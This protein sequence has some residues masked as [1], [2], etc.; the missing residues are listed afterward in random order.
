MNITDIYSAALLA[1]YDDAN[2]QRMERLLVSARHNTTAAHEAELA[3]C[4]ES[5]P[6]EIRRLCFGLRIGDDPLYPYVERMYS[7]DGWD[8]FAM[9]RIAWLYAVSKQRVHQLVKAASDAFRAHKLAPKLREMLYDR[10]EYGAD[11]FVHSLDIASKTYVS[12]DRYL[13]GARPASRMTIS[14]RMVER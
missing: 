4:V 7:S 10:I 3:A 14:Q 11:S 5:I 8:S 2:V 1:V 12:D 9:H 13:V 6:D